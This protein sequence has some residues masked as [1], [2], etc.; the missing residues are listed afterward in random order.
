MIVQTSDFTGKWEISIGFGSD[1]LQQY[2]DEYEPIILAQL[3]GADFADTITTQF[4][5]NTLTPE[6]QTLFD[7]LYFNAKVC[8][9]NKLF[10]S[11]GIQTMLKDFIYA[12]Y[13]V[14]DLGTPTSQGKIKMKTEGGELVDD[15]YTDR[16]N[17]YNSGV[18]TYRAIQKYIEEN[19]E[20]YPDYKGVKKST[21][22]LI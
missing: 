2:I 22:W 17:F 6:N 15:D 11:E 16:F 10:V 5:G 7:K 4:N 18:K 12:H 19:E 1:K 14:G 8:G 9:N 13:Q 20:D 21:T 3:L